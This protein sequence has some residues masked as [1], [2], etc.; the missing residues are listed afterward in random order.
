MKGGDILT[1]QR[2][3]GHGNITITMKG[4]LL[5]LNNLDSAVRLSLVTAIC[6]GTHIEKRERSLQWRDSSFR[7]A[8][9][10]FL[11]SHLLAH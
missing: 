6:R 7:V 1:L 5:S 4:A 3:L 9:E 8:E 10:I 11:L 2:I